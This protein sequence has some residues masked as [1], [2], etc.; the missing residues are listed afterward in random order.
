MEGSIVN[1]FLSTGCQKLVKA[2]RGKIFESSRCQKVAL[3]VDEH[4][5]DEP[6][7][8]LVLAIF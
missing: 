7:L 3:D 4:N 8:D 1:I 6:I 2:I 5:D